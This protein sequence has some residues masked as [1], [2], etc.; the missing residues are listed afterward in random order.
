VNA[1]VTEEAVLGALRGIRPRDE[2]R[3]VVALGLVRDLAITGSE[4]SLTLAFTNQPPAIKA[5]LHSAARRAIAQLAGVTE[6]K[7]RMGSAAAP[8]TQAPSGHAPRAAAVDFIPEV[9]HTVAVSSGKGGVGKST[10]AVNLAMALRDTGALVGMIDAD[11]YG[12]DVPLM[13]GS[14]GRPGMFEN[15]IIPVE[16]HGVKLMS[17]G[18]L[19]E[20]R[21]PLIWRGPMLDSFIKQMLRDVLWGP[22]DYL[23]FDMPPGTGD[24]QLSL[25]QTVPLSGAVIVTT[26]QDVALL[27]VRR[28]IAMFRKLK[29]PVLGVVENMSYF[30]CPH[31][32]ER[33]HIFGSAGGRRVAEEYDI[34]LLAQIPLDLE[35]RAGGDE[36][37]PIT[38]RKPKSAP[39]AAFRQLA[40]AVIARIG[41]ASPK[42]PSIS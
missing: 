9:K 13:L 35:T 32:Q 24:A 17:L 25:S 34:P 12:P 40:E 19:V 2:T 1:V 33:T 5:E 20:D 8:S 41:E 42:L 3:D 26:P 31:C 7:V 6:V 11:A 10:V 36:G 29:V 4:V 23:V 14:R 22:L 18:L 38:V 30:A 37:M 28:A 16:A 15:R 27:D 21:E 39:A